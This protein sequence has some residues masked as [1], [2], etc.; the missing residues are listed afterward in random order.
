MGDVR[1]EQVLD[2]V[3]EVVADGGL[4]AATIR[5]VAAEADVSL[6]LVQYYFRTKDQLIEA[7]FLHVMGRVKARTLT[8]DLDGSSLSRLRAFIDEWL[9][10][11][12]KRVGHARVWLAFSA[13]AMNNESLRSIN[14][15]VDKDI[16]AQ[17]ARLLRAAQSEG[18]LAVEIDTNLHASML[19]A[20]VD[21]LVT[22]ALLAGKRRSADLASESLD[23]YFESVFG[24]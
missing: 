5:S 6:A 15:G 23:E 10:L 12:A 11:D 7:A 4:A 2:A 21:G 9:P 13:A 17:F 3:V 20:F 22:H 1:R 18:E 24:A 8:V 16:R 14:A 19:L